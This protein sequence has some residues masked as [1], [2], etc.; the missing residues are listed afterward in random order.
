MALAAASVT[1]KVMVDF[2]IVTLIKH[3][4]Y[5]Y[6]LPSSLSLIET[7]KN[8]SKPPIHFQIYI[9]QHTFLKSRKSGFGVMYAGIDEPRR[10]ARN[11]MII[12]GLSASPRPEGHEWMI[13][14]T[15][16]KVHEPMVMKGGIRLGARAGRPPAWAGET[17]AGGTP[18]LPVNLPRRVHKNLYPS[19]SICDK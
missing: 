12:T 16:G 18:A 14:H 9:F 17:L 15:T 2:G 6:N 11:E 3:S 1:V 19:A 7:D 10:P 4:P 13:S 5:R 8:Y